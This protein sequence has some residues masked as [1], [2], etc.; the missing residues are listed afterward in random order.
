MARLCYLKKFTKHALWT[1]GDNSAYGCVLFGPY[2]VVKN[3]NH[4]SKISGISHKSPDFCS[5]LHIR[6]SGYTVAGV[7]SW[8]QSAGP[9][10]GN[11][12]GKDGALQ[13]TTVPLVPCYSLILFTWPYTTRI[14]NLCYVLGKVLRLARY[15]I[16]VLSL[17][18]IF[19]GF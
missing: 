8:H 18:N 15:Y 1:R 12:H 9:S 10:G 13:F 14:Y 3:L 11:S 4:L 16:I 6:S 17:R 7:L 19:G 5:S 2:S